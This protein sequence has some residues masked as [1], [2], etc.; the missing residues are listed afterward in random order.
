MHCWTKKIIKKLWKEFVLLVQPSKTFLV[1][2]L[3][4]EPHMEK[5]V[6]IEI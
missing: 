5:N 6:S 2:I 3:S 4:S 1:Q